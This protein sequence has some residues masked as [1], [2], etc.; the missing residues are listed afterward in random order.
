MERVQGTFTIDH[1]NGM[2]LTGHWQLPYKEGEIR[3]VACDESGRIVAEEVRYS[4]GEAK[5]ILLKPQKQSLR[6]NGADLL[7]LEISMEDENGYPVENANNRVLIQTEGAGALVGTDEE[8]VRIQRSIKSLVEDCSVEN[9][10][11]YLKQGQNL[12]I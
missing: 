7:F 12:E 10:W 2:E 4:F 11:Q 3:A 6:A 8:T 1:E 5:R 9:F